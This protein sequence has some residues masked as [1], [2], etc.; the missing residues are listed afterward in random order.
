MTSVASADKTALV[1]DPDNRRQRAAQTGPTEDTENGISGLV[2]AHE[3]GADQGPALQENRGVI[4]LGVQFL[5]QPG[6]D[7]GGGFVQDGADVGVGLGEEGAG[8][9]DIVAVVLL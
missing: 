4:F 6:G 2:F 8:A 9:L 7:V 1:G 3:G 5:L